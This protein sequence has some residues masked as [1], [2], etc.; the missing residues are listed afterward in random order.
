MYMVQQEQKSSQCLK[1]VSP[2]Y[3][4]PVSRESTPREIGVDL[5]ALVQGGVPV[6]GPWERATREQTTLRDGYRISPGHR[7]L[8]RAGGGYVRQR[9]SHAHRALRGGPGARGGPQAQKLPVRARLQVG[10]PRAAAAAHLLWEREMNL[11]FLDG[12]HG[13]VCL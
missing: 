6:H 2:A 7:H 13:G 12:L 4:F 9:L 10:P 11:V 5:V 1:G 8:L 3:Q